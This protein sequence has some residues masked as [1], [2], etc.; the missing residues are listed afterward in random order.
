MHDGNE[1]YQYI[2]ASL[3]LHTTL[4]LNV[5]AILV[6]KMAF[7]SERGVGLSLPMTLRL[8]VIATVGP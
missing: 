3:Q 1:D 6:P 7:V 8:R 5:L 2:I 4:S